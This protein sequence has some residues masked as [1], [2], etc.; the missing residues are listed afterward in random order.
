MMRR[1]I[2]FLVALCSFCSC[3]RHGAATKQEI[4]KYVFNQTDKLNCIK[5]TGAFELRLTFKPSDLIAQDQVI[6]TNKNEFDSLSNV[7]SKFYYF[8]LEIN[9][10]GK[11]LGQYYVLKEQDFIREINQVISNACLIDQGSKCIN[12]VDYSI[13][14]GFGLTPNTYIM[15]FNKP[16][17]REFD[18]VVESVNWGLER[19]AFTFD[20]KEIQKVPRLIN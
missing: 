12:P 17:E 2:I 16:S 7:Y 19:T 3:A 8:V 11:D 6:T 4:I 5:K 18:I 10:K 14:N 20:K 13:I 1:I 15:A 9:Y